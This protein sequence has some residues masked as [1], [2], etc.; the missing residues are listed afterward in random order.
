MI[1]FRLVT[2]KYSFDTQ[3]WKLLGLN[4]LQ[5]NTKNINIFG[6]KKSTLKLKHSQTIILSQLIIKLKK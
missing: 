3:F 2:K 6:P 5:I 4:S 1:P